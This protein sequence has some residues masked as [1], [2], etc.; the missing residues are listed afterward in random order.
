MSEINQLLERLVALCDA[1]GFPMF[2]TIQDG[3]KS[4]LTSH[5]N[6]GRS[7]W[8]KLHHMEILNRTW[9]IDQFLHQVIDE[10]RVG[11]HDSLYLMAMGV[12]KTPVVLPRLPVR[13]AG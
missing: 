6:I 1:E 5:V 9:N 4:F 12:P 8:E 10:A 2:C 11:G 13:R 3:E 7:A